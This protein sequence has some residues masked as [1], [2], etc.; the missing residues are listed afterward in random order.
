M[1]RKI[2]ALA[3]VAACYGVSASAAE[4][5]TWK[6]VTSQRVFVTL[7][8]ERRTGSGTTTFTLRAGQALLATIANVGV[9]WGTWRY[10]STTPD[11]YCGARNGDGVHRLTPIRQSQRAMRNHRQNYSPQNSTSKLTKR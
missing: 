9:N 4:T 7:G 3:F 1:K 2:V 8:G 11:Q 5:G 6:N 10:E